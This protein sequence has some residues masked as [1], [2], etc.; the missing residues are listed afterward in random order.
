MNLYAFLIDSKFSAAPILISCK[1]FSFH[2]NGIISIFFDHNGI[3]LLSVKINICLIW[4]QILIFH[5]YLNFYM[6][7]LPRE[8][9][10]SFREHRHRKLKY[11]HI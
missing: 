11:L 6:H 3:H 5:I 1:I 7:E 9:P 4:I 2:I 8:W 10:H